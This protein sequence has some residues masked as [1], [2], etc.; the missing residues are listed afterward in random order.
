[1]KKY[2]IPVVLFLV[3]VVGTIIFG[4]SLSYKTVQYGKETS[5]HAAR[6]HEGGELIAEYD[7]VTTKVV[8]QNVD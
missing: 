7:G 4:V 5:L 8:G 1:M 6:V 2:V 3:V